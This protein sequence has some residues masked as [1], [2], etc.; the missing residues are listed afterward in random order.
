MH[1]KDEL[2][3]YGQALL[4]RGLVWGS[5]GNISSRA[6]GN[7]FIISASGADLGLLLDDDLIPC[8]IDPKSHEGLRQPSMEVDLHRNIYRACAE[9]NAVIHSQPFNSTLAACSGIDIRVDLIPEAM[10]YLKRVI[11]VPYHHAGSAELAVSWDDDRLSQRVPVSVADDA[12]TDLAIDPSAATVHP[13]QAIVYQVTG[14]RGGE[15]RVLG[16]TDGLQILV[17]DP[18]VARPTADST[19]VVGGSPGRTAIVAQ[20]GQERAEAVLDVVPGDG[21]IGTAVVGDFH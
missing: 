14:M 11:R 18:D 13:G 12:I 8:K 6:D 19:A 17:D 20:L 7:T 21:P 4:Q 1:Y 3:I 10:A 9:A 16:P 15:R 5:S 2:M